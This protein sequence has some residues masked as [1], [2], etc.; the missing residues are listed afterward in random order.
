[1]DRTEITAGESVRLSINVRNSG[2][3]DGAEA[4]QL[5]IRDDYGSITRPVKELKGVKKI[6]LKAGESTTVEFEITPEMLEC[7]GAS[8]KWTVEPGTFTI[9]A[10]SSSDDKDLGATHLTVL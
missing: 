10:G 6:F 7:W 4:V 5:Y 2:A 1:M 3:L 8:E 9:M